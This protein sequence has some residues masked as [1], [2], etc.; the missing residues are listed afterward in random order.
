M[1]NFIKS[2]ILLILLL[3][4]LV[5]FIWYI[6]KKV[7]KIDN[8]LEEVLKKAEGAAFNYTNDLK[9]INKTSTNIKTQQRNILKDIEAINQILD[10][11]KG[12]TINTKIYNNMASDLK[13]HIENSI[14]SDLNIKD[15]EIDLNI[16]PN[17]KKF[18]DKIDEF[19]KIGN[20][21]DSKVS[22]FTN[23][24]KNKFKKSVDNVEKSVDNSIED[25]QK[26]LVYLNDLLKEKNKKI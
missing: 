18:R 22:N 15:I 19:N 20:V 16:E 6:S 9:D 13:N 1:D 7:K 26:D 10:K 17:I 24:I 12:E 4:L 3:I 14:S 23:N 11:Y 25:E 2:V 5:I 21:K 8:I